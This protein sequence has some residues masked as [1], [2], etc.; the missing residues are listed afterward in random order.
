MESMER[1]GFNDTYRDKN[2]GFK[3]SW[4][5]TWLLSLGAK[6]IGISNGIP[7]KPSLFELIKLE[8]EITHYVE[9]VRNTEGIR[10]IV[11]TERPDFIF[12]LA[13]QPIVSLSYED[14]LET[15]S[16]N[17][18]GIANVLDSLREVDFN[19][20]VVVVTSDKC[21]D[22]VEWVWGYKETD[23]LGGKDIYSG[24]KGAEELIS[25]SYYHSFFNKPDSHVRM[26]TVRAGN[27]IGGGD[28]AK[29]RIVPDVIRAWSK[30]DVLNMRSPAATRPWQHVLDPLSGYLLV[31]QRL[32]ENPDLN[33]DA[34]NFGP[35]QEFNTSV[36]ELVEDLAKIWGFNR[37]E[38]GY[39]II[40]KKPF[41]EATL[42]KLNC[43]KALLELK[44]IPVLR[45]AEVIE[46]TGT[47]YKEW[48]ENNQN[49]MEFTIKQI[50][51]YYKLARQHELIWAV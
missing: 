28:W 18:M 21:Y 7:T 48:V 15:I 1:L 14:P 45:Y 41:D 5:T 27:I 6:V 35:R 26:V 12:H 47:W 19:C 39:K 8:D 29:D 44:W 33:G 10:K 46:F 31:G 4:L 11:Q 51:E 24:S 34:Y 30:N 9:D 36:L 43:D 50:K 16:T 25:K 17:T 32:D 42:L 2:T 49:L 20:V 40:E 38:D 37:I 13:A 23:Y 3:G 22:N